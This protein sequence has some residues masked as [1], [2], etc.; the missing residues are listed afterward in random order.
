ME[1]PRNLKVSAGVPCTVWRTSYS[2][3]LGSLALQ[4]GGLGAS[5]QQRGCCTRRS[6]PRS[7]SDLVVAGGDSQITAELAER[8]L[9]S[10]ELKPQRASNLA[11]MGDKLA[12][13][14]ECK[15]SSCAAGLH[16]LTFR[17]ANILACEELRV[18]GKDNLKNHGCVGNPTHLAHWKCPA[19]SCLF[20]A[21]EQS[22]SNP[23][24]FVPDDTRLGHVGQPKQ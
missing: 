10:L 6:S 2:T 9:E 19:L 12:H 24:G 13:N 23:E 7:N 1:L 8:C 11:S 4:Q 17:A 3:C 20:V 15:Q 5:T 16:T 21:A 14:T 22:K 18:L